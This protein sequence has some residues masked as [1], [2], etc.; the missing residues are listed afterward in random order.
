MKPE[1]E[2]RIF[3]YIDLEPPKPG[4]WKAGV[5]DVVEQA[6]ETGWLMEK[7]AVRKFA[8]TQR[9]MEASQRQFFRKHYDLDLS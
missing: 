1:N 5:F 3:G 7:Y 4:S 9:R 8:A 6:E 2:Q